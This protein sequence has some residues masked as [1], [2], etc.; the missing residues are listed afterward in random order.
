MKLGR[1]RR[2]QYLL[3]TLRGL[4]TLGVGLLVLNA[5]ALFADAKG[6]DV[7]RLMPLDHEGVQEL[8]ERSERLSLSPSATNDF[9]VDAPSVYRT[10]TGATIVGGEIRIAIPDEPSHGTSEYRYARRAG[11]FLNNCWMKL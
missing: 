1:K 7:A 2:I 9:S 3:T 4:T 11:R 8:K 10:E 6:R 5:V